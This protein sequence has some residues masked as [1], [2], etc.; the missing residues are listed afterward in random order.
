M[1]NTLRI[2][3]G[4]LWQE[5]NTFNPIPTTCADFEHFG[6][7]S[8]YMTTEYFHLRS[9]NFATMQIQSE[10]RFALR[11]PSSLHRHVVFASRVGERCNDSAREEDN[12][13]PPAQITVQRDGVNLTN[14]FALSDRD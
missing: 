2:A 9:R 6:I 8:L 7:R 11:N 10:Q 13:M 3:V 14:R 4:Q 5:S 12:Q 1:T